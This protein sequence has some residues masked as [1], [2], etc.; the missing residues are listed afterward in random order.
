[1]PASSIHH[2][3]SPKWSLHDIAALGAATIPV[4]YGALIFI[5]CLRAGETV[6][7]HAAAG[8]LGVHA[9]QIAKALGA[10]VIGTVGSDQK[11]SV[12]EELI[13]DSK[14]RHI[15]EGEGV[16]NYS[17]NDWQEE[18]LLICRQNGKDGVD[19]VFDTVGLVQKS[20]KCTAFHG[21]IIIVGFAARTG[22][23]A[24]KV[25]DL[26]QIAVNRLLLKQIKL[27]G[28]R[29]GETSRRMPQE[30]AKLWTGL[31]ELLAKDPRLIKPVIYK[32]YKG[33]DAVN[34][35]MHALSDRKVFGKAVVE[36]CPEAEALRQVQELQSCDKDRSKPRL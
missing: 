7:V 5:G 23:G 14:T 22:T 15:P 6:L 19:V 21:R 1:M 18:V 28:Y 31:N 32:T 10:K 24:R 33:L 2:V 17:N 9:V 26:E 12:V 30:T 36:I 8:G 34:E 25:Q 16:V 13:R 3:P 27:L 11:K 20:I 29:F 35:A 4:S